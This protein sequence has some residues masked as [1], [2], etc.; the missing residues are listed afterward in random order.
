ML[1]DGALVFLFC[2]FFWLASLGKVPLS[3]DPVKNAE[4]VRKMAPIARI[5]GPIGVIAGLLMMLSTLVRA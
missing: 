1:I 4:A 3:S 2:G 5:F